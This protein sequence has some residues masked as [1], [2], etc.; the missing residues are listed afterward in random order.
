MCEVRDL[1]HLDKQSLVYEFK[2]Q[3]EK[4]P[5]MSADEVKQES[6]EGGEQE[7]GLSGGINETSIKMM[8]Y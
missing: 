2:R 8:Y 6:V 3:K 5:N 4:R 1:K 7:T